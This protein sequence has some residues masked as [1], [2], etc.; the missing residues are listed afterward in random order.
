MAKY[1][2]VTCAGIRSRMPLSAY[3]P[4]PVWMVMS[5]ETGVIPGRWA[6]SSAG[7][8]LTCQCTGAGNADGGTTI[9]SPSSAPP[10][11]DTVSVPP[12]VDCVWSSTMDWAVAKNC[13]G[14]RTVTIARATFVIATPPSV[15]APADATPFAPVVTDGT[16]R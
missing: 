4:T 1:P 5:G 16:A 7:R 2:G 10:G 6:T 8:A 12:A 9:C 3:V 13:T 14:G 11:C 15:Q